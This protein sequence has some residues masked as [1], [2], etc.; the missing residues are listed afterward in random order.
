MPDKPIRQ[1]LGEIKADTC[2]LKKTLQNH[3]AHHFQ[4]TLWA[5]GIAISVIGTLIILIL[6]WKT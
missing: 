3:L 4:Y 1:I 6:K 2:W 5:W